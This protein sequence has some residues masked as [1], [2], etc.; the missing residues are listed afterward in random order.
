M[1]RKKKITR[2]RIDPE[3]QEQLAELGFA[4]QEEVRELVESRDVSTP[5]KLRAVQRW[6]STDGT[7]AGL[8]V[9]PER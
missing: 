8:L 6:Q 1:F 2:E 9:L 7:K 5:E 3:L 4:S